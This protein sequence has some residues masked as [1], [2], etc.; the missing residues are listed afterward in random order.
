MNFDLSALRQEFPFFS[1]HPEW[2]YLDNAATLHKPQAVFDAMN[3]FYR[4]QNSNVHRSAHGLSQQAT[5][6]FETART[7]VAQF[8]NARFSHEIIWTSGTTAGFNQLV[9]GLMGPVLQ[10]G[11]RVLISSMEHHAN[12]VPWHIHAL[13]FGVELDVVP[14]TADHRFDMAAFEE[15]LQLKPK[16]VSISHVSNAL[17]HIQQVADIVR[18]AKAAGAIVV[19]DGAQ[20]IVWQ[21]IDVQALDVDFYLFSG[22]KLYGPTGI[23]VLYGKTRYLALLRPLLGGGEMIKTVSFTQSSWNDLPYRLEAGTP[24]IAAAVGLGAAILWLQQQDLTAFQQHKTALVQR[25]YDGCKQ[26]PLL[27][28]LSGPTT[29]AGIVALNLKNEHP[30]DLATLLDQQNIAVRAG[31]HCAMPL[32]NTM[33]VKGSVRF[34]FAC[35]NSFDEVDRTLA[36]LTTAVELLSE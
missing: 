3:E 10:S 16:V 22:H 2:I 17:G 31:T 30:A 36:A 19:L 15:L 28:L 32:F 18:L 4:S 35:Y 26:I 6:A 13:P 34:S 20:G 5:T 14:L 9:F 8:L 21:R 7:T 11:D 29:N 27:D 1:A 23:G 33:N 12:I 24:N 25:F